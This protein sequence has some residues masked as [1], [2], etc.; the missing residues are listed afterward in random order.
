M[1]YIFDL[2][3][4]KCVACG[5][6]AVACMDQ[7]DISLSEGEKPFRAVAAVERPGDPK[8]EIRYIS[9]GCMHCENAPCVAACP[10][11]CL[12]KNEMGL[13]EY[14][15]SA[16][17]GCHSCAMACPFGAPTFAPGGKMTKCHGCQV[18]LEQG[19]LPACVRVC[20]TGALTCVPEEEYWKKHK[21]QGMRAI[22]DK[23]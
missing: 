4:S 1:K 21:E 20:P 7:N 15:N 9:M 22:V 19:M 12:E 6:C 17:I 5:A 8:K 2:D 10:M 18:R 23:M 3:Y 11:G 16:C 14:D 13:T